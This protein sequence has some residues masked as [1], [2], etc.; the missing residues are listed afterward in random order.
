MCMVWRSCKKGQGPL[1]VDGQR[2]YKMCGLKRLKDAYDESACM[3]E[4]CA[5]CV[6]TVQLMEVE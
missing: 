2:V 6:H 4:V 3:R 1:L 5:W